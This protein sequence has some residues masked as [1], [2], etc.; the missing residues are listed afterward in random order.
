MRTT[1]ENAIKKQPK[2][3]KARSL[4]IQPKY[5]ASRARALLKPK[6]SIVPELTLCGKWLQ[7]LGFNVNARVAVYASDQQIVIRPLEV[8]E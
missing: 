7:E 8:E 3:T 1:K 2:E 6:P 4:K 5:R